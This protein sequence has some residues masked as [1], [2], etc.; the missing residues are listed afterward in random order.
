MGDSP[1]ISVD[2]NGLVDAKSNFPLTQNNTSA[3]LNK[4]WTHYK[5]SFKNANNT[6]SNDYIIP[7]FIYLPKNTTSHIESNEWQLYRSFHI[8]ALS[9]KMKIMK[10][11]EK[12]K[13]MNL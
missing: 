11:E 12:V 13:K 7:Y 8:N 3:N 2:F 4:S 5:K 9:Y 1:S 6:K 10:A